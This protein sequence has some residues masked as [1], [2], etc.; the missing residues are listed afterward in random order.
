MNNLLT[1]ITLTTR[2]FLIFC[3]RTRFAI[4]LVPR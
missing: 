2:I 3:R 4:G 1:L